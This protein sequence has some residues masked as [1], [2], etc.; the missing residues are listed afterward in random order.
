VVNLGFDRM[1]FPRPVF[2][3]DTLRVETLIVDKRESRSRAD[4]GIV[5]FDHR[6]FNQREELVCSIIRVALLQRSEA[7]P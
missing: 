4:A 6:V 1:T 2:I 7:R 5:T 3:G